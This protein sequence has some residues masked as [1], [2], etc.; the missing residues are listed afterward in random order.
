MINSAAGDIRVVI[1]ED[2]DTIREG[3]TFLIGQEEGFVIAGAYASVEEAMPQL[4]GDD[5][6]ILL[7]DVQL[8]G[9]RGIDALPAIRKILPDMPVLILSVYESEDIIFTALKNGASGYLTKNLPAPKIMASIREAIDGGGPMSPGIA[10][11]V[12]RSFQKSSHSPLSRRETQVLESIS[13]GKSRG[14]IAAE[15]YIDTETVK[16]HIRNI[17]YKLNVNSREEALK[18]ARDSKFI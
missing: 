15:L 6:H 11:M 4:A 3:Y 7:L 17:Y 14:K 1:I 12:I 5:P 2:D 9:I 10:G 16:T 13:A 18:V 8:P